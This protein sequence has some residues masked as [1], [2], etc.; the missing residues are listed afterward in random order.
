MLVTEKLAIIE[1]RI[2]PVVSSSRRWEQ[3]EWIRR[4]TRP[5]VKES[6]GSNDTV[7]Q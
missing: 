1:G 3:I 6:I 7:S 2:V 4:A 5:K